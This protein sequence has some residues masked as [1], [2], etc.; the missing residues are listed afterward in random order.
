MRG[1]W[2]AS[3]AGLPT[4]AECFTLHFTPATLWYPTEI[5]VK[6]KTAGHLLL[7]ADALFIKA[8]VYRGYSGR[9]MFGKTTTG[10]AIDRPMSVAAIAAQAATKFEENNHDDNEPYDFSMF[11]E[12]L[13][14]LRTDSLGLQT[15]VY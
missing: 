3:A 14:N 6:Q 2:G 8:A 9:G 7:A 15:I 10:I 11:I 12:D 4:A 13:L 5:H 1:R